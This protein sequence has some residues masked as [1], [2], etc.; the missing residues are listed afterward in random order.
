LLN[1][2]LIHK[3]RSIDQQTGA[4]MNSEK[5]AGKKLI[6]PVEKNGKKLFLEL[7]V[8]FLGVTAG[9]L[10]NNWKQDSRDHQLEQKYLEGFAEDAQANFQ[11]LSSYTKSDS[12]WISQVKPK[13]NELREQTITHDSALVLLKSIVVIS[14]STIH[15]GTYENITNSGNLN[16]IRNYDLKKLIVDYHVSAKGVEFIDNYFYQYFN[17]YV[18]PFVFENFNILDGTLNNPKIIHS[19]RFSNII[20]G[21]F[22]MVQQRESAYKD[23]LNKSITLQRKLKNNP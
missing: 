19:T 11:E 12:L 21:Y 20:A 9:F 4:M 16:L 1:H 14:K 17:N 22:S 6:I 2:C 18:M 10:L 23:L 7:L 3:I 15:T 5:K 8:V 13:L